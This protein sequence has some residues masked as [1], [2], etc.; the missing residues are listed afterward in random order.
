[1]SFSSPDFAN[2][3]SSGRLSPN[4]TC[5]T[6]V[7]NRVGPQVSQRPEVRTRRCVISVTGM[8]CT[9]CVGTIER[10][11]RSH[12]GE[13]SAEPPV[14]PRLSC[15]PLARRGR[16]CL[17][18]ADGG[19]SR[20]HV[21][22][23]RDRRRRRGPADRSSGLLRHGGGAR[24][25]SRQAGPQ[26]E[27]AVPAGAEDTADVCHSFQVSGAPPASTNWSP[28]WGLR[29]ASWPPRSAWPPAALSSATSPRRS[30]RETFWPSSRCWPRLDWAPESSAWSLTSALLLQD[31]G[32]QAEL[33][34]PGVKQNL[35]HWAEI[36]Q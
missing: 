30:E 21:R 29:A 8:T 6:I 22:P 25:D 35:D 16:C 36:Q 28:N 3:S 34:K 19:K 1:M 32:F 17:C 33:D 27:C 31:L 9:S 15:R 13:L 18:V 10:T 14:P 2:T 5:G 11:L 26:G 12:G 24:R 20:G 4:Q 7:G 23:R